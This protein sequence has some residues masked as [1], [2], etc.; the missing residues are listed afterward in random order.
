MFRFIAR[1]LLFITAVSIFIIYIAN[2][3]MAMTV[4]SDLP[5]PSYDLIEYSRQATTEY[6]SDIVHG[7]LGTVDTDYGMVELSDYLVESYINSAGLLLVSL[8]VATVLGL[9]IGSWAALTKHQA[10]SLSFLTITIIGISV[11]SFFAAILLQQ[12]A[13]R[14]QQ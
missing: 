14:Y 9:L 10:I 6:I 13:I 12:F 5:E 8:T 1:R 11:P 3:G 4:N 7:D 2:L